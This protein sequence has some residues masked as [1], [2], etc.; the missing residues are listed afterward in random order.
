V[1]DVIRVKEQQGVVEEVGIRTTRLRT[2][3][4]VLVLVPNAL[5]FAEVVSNH[6]FAQASA[7]T[8]PATD[9]PA[10]SPPSST[11]AAAATATG[12]TPGGA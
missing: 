7:P 6:T 3:E 1:G 10:T 2:T 4:N 8:P 12:H 5:V 11:S 9:N